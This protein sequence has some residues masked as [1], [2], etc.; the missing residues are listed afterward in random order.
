[1]ALAV[2]G[3]LTLYIK[4]RLDH[5]NYKLKYKQ[6]RPLPGYAVVPQHLHALAGHVRSYQ[7]GSD[8]AD[9]HRIEL[10]LT[11]GANP[12]EVYKRTG[13]LYPKNEPSIWECSLA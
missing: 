7:F 6:G 9:H 12:G 8:Y 11:Y 1:M 3:N 2:Q 13:N 10:L 4:G 5:A